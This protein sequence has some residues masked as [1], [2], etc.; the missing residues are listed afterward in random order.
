[1]FLI[2]NRGTIIRVREQSITL[3]SSANAGVLLA[4]ASVQS[5]HCE[6]ATDDRGAWWIKNLSSRQIHVN[7][8]ALGPG[9]SIRFVQPCEVRIPPHVIQLR[10]TAGSGAIS[11]RL[12]KKFFDLESQ[13][14]SAVLD[15]LKLGGHPDAAQQ[16][17]KKIE[18]ELERQFNLLNLE[19]EL[20]TYLAAQALISLLNDQIHSYGNPGAMAPSQRRAKEIARRAKLVNRVAELIQVD[21]D[22]TAAEQ[23]ERVEVLVPWVL[24][25]HPDLLPPEDRRELAI[26]L[27]RENLIDSIFGLGPMQDL[28]NAKEINDIMVLPSG[29]IYI[30]R[31]G[32]M[33][34]S[35]RKMLSPEV[36]RRIIEKIITKE[37]RRIDQTSPMVDAR[38]MDGSR[39]NAVIEPVAVNGP[40]LTIRRFPQKTMGMVDLVE[41]GTLTESVAGFLTACVV[42]RKSLII[43]GGTGSGKTT[44][45]NALAAKI[46]ENERIITVEDT[47][48]I[49]LP[50][51][52]VVTLQAK[53]ANLEGENAVSIRQLV[54]NTLRMRPDRIIVGEC[55]GGETLD[56]LQAMNTGHDGS[57]TTIHANT[58]WD[59]RH[60]LETLAMEAEGINL[61]SRALREQIVSAVDLVIQISRVA[62]RI[63]RVTS[64]CEVVGIDEENGAIILEEVFAYRRRKG[65]GL[66]TRSA[67]VFTGYVP[68]F[69]DQ[70][71]EAGADLN[72]LQ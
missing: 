67:L 28:M 40:T 54:R 7:G 41:N 17:Q 15:R 32:Q 49:R 61:P 22:K 52:H 42:A 14:H 31:N 45:L 65:K 36:A 48:E 57:M 8:S 47:A 64:I 2:L 33:Q 13:L 66:F 68:T 53:T 19:P 4:G 26:A 44:L 30:E 37:G 62:H 16:E 38:V 35:G 39:L 18:I 69:F 71:I 29:H 27:L 34:D 46:P 70:L 58:P 3:G 55:R 72:C 59:A 11:Q 56:M 9:A 25:A 5:L 60:R 63:R 6:V 10:E 43:S 12:R 21:S 51:V 24:Q 23:V 20:E 1:M 50:Q